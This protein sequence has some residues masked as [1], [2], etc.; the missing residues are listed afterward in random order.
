MSV[1]KP[2]FRTLTRDE[3]H[4]VLARNHVGRIAYAKG[5]AI[6]I[7]P[8]LYI[9]SEGWLYGRTSRGTRLRRTGE[10]WWPV[11]FEIDEVDGPFDWKS[12]VVH[13]GFYTLSPSGAAWEQKQYDRA[14][15]LLRTMI[16]E[17]FT[18]D[19]PTPFRNV[20]FRIAVQEVSG[21]ASE[22][23]PGS[24]YSSQ[25][26]LGRPGRYDAPVVAIGG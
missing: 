23:T 8:I 1:N 10:S 12:V 9:Y 14:V 16:P 7:E 18:P 20:V 5:N 11:A 19:D 4:E 3:I 13:G 15:E 26:F 6:D 24:P 2:A 21:R 25:A 17:T 22:T